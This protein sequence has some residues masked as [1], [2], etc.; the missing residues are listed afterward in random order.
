MLY[1]VFKNILFIL[2]SIDKKK[3][4]M[5]VCNVYISML[6]NTKIQMS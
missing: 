5:F 2:N 1:Y 3:L 6:N 4:N